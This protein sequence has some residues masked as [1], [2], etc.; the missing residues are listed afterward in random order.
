[1]AAQ[2]KKGNFAGLR[3]LSLYN[4]PQTQT[5]ANRNRPIA[6]D[7]RN[8][9]E[10][11]IKTSSLFSLLFAAVVSAA[12]LAV[13]AQTPVSD[14]TAKDI[15][16]ALRPATG[17]GKTRGTRNLGVQKNDV[18][19]P[20]A[21]TPPDS[22]APSEPAKPAKPAS[23]DLAIQFDFNSSKISAA[24]RKTLDTLA[25]ALASPE[26]ASMKFRIE[27]HTDSKGSAAYNQKLSEARAGAVKNALV[28]HKIDGSRL[29]A[30]GKGST[31]PLNTADTTAAENR[32]VRIVTM[33]Q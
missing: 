8:F 32:R 1:V 23:I 3:L 4:F 33:E 18:D 12:P 24:S 30:V 14:P 29:T 10:V 22:A 13:S 15:I 20:A 31:E 9:R 2:Y 25:V 5:A 16:D 28:A 17:G 21:G 11:I 6:A 7:F 26:L 19:A 27:G